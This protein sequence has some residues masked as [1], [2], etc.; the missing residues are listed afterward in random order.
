MIK[1]EIKMLTP[2]TLK[3]YG[4]VTLYWVSKPKYSWKHIGF[5]LFGYGVS[6][7]RWE[8]SGAGE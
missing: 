2:N 6:Y 3:E 8:S 5:A 7:L 1:R 4:P